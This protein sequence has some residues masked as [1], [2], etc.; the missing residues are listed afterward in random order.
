ME[1]YSQASHLVTEIITASA[2]MLEKSSIDEFYIDASGMDRFF[3]AFKWAC[4]LRK[5]VMAGKRAS[6]LTGNVR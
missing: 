2:P 3:G 4:E 5:N 1:A 6:H